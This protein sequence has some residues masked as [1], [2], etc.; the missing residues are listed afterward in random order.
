MTPDYG[1][2][3]QPVNRSVNEADNG[4]KNLRGTVAM[5]RTNDVNSATAQF[6][7]NVESKRRT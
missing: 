5:A 2:Q 3:N 4:L 6:F 7:I 1:G